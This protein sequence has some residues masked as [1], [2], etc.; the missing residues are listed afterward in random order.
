MQNDPPERKPQESRPPSVSVQS[1]VMRRIMDLVVRLV[2]V[3][4]GL[5]PNAPRRNALVILCYLVFILLVVGLL[6]R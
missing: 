2:K 4:P 3:V 1:L 5:R 6:I